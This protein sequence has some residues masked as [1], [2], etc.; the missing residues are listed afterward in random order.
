ML[1]HSLINS[2]IGKKMLVALAG[3]FLMIFLL[4]H[5]S[6]NLLLLVGD[7]GILFNQAAH[8]MASNFIILKMQ[9]VLAFALLLH[10]AVAI[11][12]SLQNW[13]ARPDR[14]IVENS[15]ETNFF[16]KYM[17]H[18]GG[19]IFVFL[20]IHLLNFFYKMKFTGMDE[21]QSFDLVSGLFRQWQYSA[22]YIVSMLFL[23]FHLNHAFQ[24]AFQTLGFNH[25][26]YTPAIKVISTTY[27]VIVSVGFI[28]IPLYFLLVK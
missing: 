5:L 14:Y 23:G 11:F 20:I 1:K 18:T 19:I 17:T 25:N 12:L 3:G 26:R 24:S 22:F 7:Q 2:S 28:M 6:I 21:N 16:S 10:V 13:L 27:A 8:F 9:F 4:V 15:T